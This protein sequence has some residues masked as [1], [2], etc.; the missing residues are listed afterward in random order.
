MTDSKIRR[1]GICIE[2]YAGLH[3]PAAQATTLNL[4]NDLVLQSHSTIRFRKMLLQKKIATPKKK[5]NLFQDVNVTVTKARPL[6]LLALTTSDNMRAGKYVRSQEKFKAPL[7]VH[8][9]FND[10]VAGK[11]WMDK[12]DGSEKGI[13]SPINVEHPQ[14]QKHVWLFMEFYGV[15]DSVHNM[16]KV[17]DR[18]IKKD[19]AL[20]LNRRCIFLNLSRHGRIYMAIM[21]NTDPNHN[22]MCPQ[23]LP[24]GMSDPFEYVPPQPARQFPAFEDRVANVDVSKIESMKYMHN[25]LAKTI[26]GIVFVGANDDAVI[27]R[28]IFVESLP[29]KETDI[30]AL[31]QQYLVIGMFTVNLE[32]LSK[33]I[34]HQGVSSKYFCVFYT[35]VN[36]QCEE[37]FHH[38]GK[39]TNIEQWTMVGMIRDGKIYKEM[40]SM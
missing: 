1:S 19:I 24:W 27:G 9:M 22:V 6:E 37:V 36:K 7:T 33:F 25:T 4:K 10:T 29:C 23:P 8:N 31:F 34:G 40:L 14:S 20:I 32:F 35:A 16:K 12:G 21:N 2:Y 13:I 15:A 26:D 5:E 30:W 39:E 18:P 17:L 11:I 38:S 3:V 28:S